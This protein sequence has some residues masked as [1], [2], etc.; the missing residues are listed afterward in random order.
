V[1][2]KVAE[3]YEPKPL[4]RS[5]SGHEYITAW[6]KPDAEE[7]LVAGK[8]VRSVE[9]PGWSSSISERTYEDIM[10]RSFII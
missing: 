5:P 1:P 2:L 10:R 8:L 4:H 6:K 7:Y 9:R 3:L